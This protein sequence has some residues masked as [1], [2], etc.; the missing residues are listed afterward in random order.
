MVLCDAYT[1]QHLI[2]SMQSTLDKTP[3]IYISASL[4][5]LSVIL[6]VFVSST[7]IEPSYSYKHPCC[8]LVS[9][10]V[11]VLSIL[12]LCYTGFHLPIQSQ[13]NQILYNRK[14]WHFAPPLSQ[15][16]AVATQV[17]LSRSI[18][19]SRLRYLNKAVSL[20]IFARNKTGSVLVLSQLHAGAPDGAKSTTACI[21]SLRIAFEI[22]L[23]DFKL[24]VLTLSPNCQI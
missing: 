12:I 6:R 17:H 11:L 9:K 4:F 14:Y 3:S 1:M 2:V 18:A 19:I 8:L 5:Y 16:L 24:A 13:N 23:G 15:Y 21:T 22:I 20:Q 7:R 10:Q